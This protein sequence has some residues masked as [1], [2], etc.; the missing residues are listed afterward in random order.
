MLIIPASKIDLH[1]LPTWFVIGFTIV[2]VTI[3]AWMLGMFAYV[4]W[5]LI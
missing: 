1:G 3:F 5:E 2:Y 4:T